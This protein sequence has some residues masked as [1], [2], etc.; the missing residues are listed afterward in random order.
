MGF[1]KCF[2][3]STPSAPA[4]SSPPPAIEPP[5]PAT[6]APAASSGKVVRAPAGQP[7]SA[8]KG[9]VPRT[10]AELHPEYAHSEPYH[11]AAN[12]ASARLVVDSAS[13]AARR[14]GDLRLR[15]ADVPQ[16]KKVVIR[17]PSYSTRVAPAAQARKVVAATSPRSTPKSPRSGTKSSRKSGVDTHR[18]SSVDSGRKS[19][20]D[21]PRKSM[22]KLVVESPAT[23]K[24]DDGTIQ[25]EN[26]LAAANPP[27]SPPPAGSSR[28]LSRFMKGG[29]SPRGK[30][31]RGKSP[32]GRS[33]APSPLRKKLSDA[34][35]PANSPAVNAAIAHTRSSQGQAQRTLSFDDG[36]GVEAA[37]RP[38]S[39][40]DGFDQA[41]AAQKR[42]EEERV[43][44]DQA[45]Y[46]D[47]E[48][49]EEPEQEYAY[50]DEHEQ[51][52]EADEEESA[53]GQYDEE[54]ASSYRSARDDEEQSEEEEEEEEEESASD[55]EA[56]S[57]PSEGQYYQQYPD[58]DRQE[59]S[60][61]ESEESSA[62]DRAVSANG[63]LTEDHAA[64][65][66]SATASVRSSIRSSVRS[67]TR[68]AAMDNYSIDSDYVHSTDGD[69][70]RATFGFMRDS[71]KTDTTVDTTT[72]DA[73]SDQGPPSARYGDRDDQDASF[74]SASSGQVS[75]VREGSFLSEVPSARGGHDQFSDANDSFTRALAS[76]S[77]RT[78]RR[79]ST[80]AGR[81]VEAYA[82]AVAASSPRARKPARAPASPH[83]GQPRRSPARISPGP[84]ENRYADYSDSEGGSMPSASLVPIGR[85]GS[86]KTT[87][88]PPR[89]T[90]SFRVDKEVVI[91]PNLRERR[92]QP[93]SSLP[94]GI[95]SGR[96][97]VS[98]LK[99]QS[100]LPREASRPSLASGKPLV[101]ALRKTQAIASPIES[102]R[103]SPLPG[104]R[105]SFTDLNPNS[106]F[107]SASSSFDSLPVRRG[108]ARLDP[109]QSRRRSKAVAEAMIE[110]IKGV[111]K[112][113]MLAYAEHEPE[114]D[115]S[116]ELPTVQLRG[117]LRP[118][119]RSGRSMR[120]PPVFTP[121]VVPPP[122]PPPPF[123]PEPT[124]VRSVRMPP[125][126]PK[127]KKNRMYC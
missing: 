45:G 97:L 77:R 21:G 111:P 83:P 81:K 61:S 65:N 116:G 67:S 104:P 92:H 86:K 82:A 69:R 66:A 22:V 101:S 10:V 96:M 40:V 11:F 75:T 20:V 68:S 6:S 124:R 95:G 112:S 59:E 70:V 78:L 122:P 42:A 8:S 16:P 98:A 62:S 58:A 119:A 105:V 123:A 3:R 110:Q 74:A 31:P 93:S 15:A 27:A 51:E 50:E 127:A 29:F 108:S 52:E 57:A 33:P 13:R 48:E 37:P 73:M 39:Y 35:P 4:L 91:E 88:A 30:S 115:M 7:T 113:A 2:N 71:A 46:G 106:S 41:A 56:S 43:W 89:K 12:T 53:D 117:S 90:V 126:P 76:G 114:D 79:D 103:A 121:G 102:P 55:G 107:L 84:E 118:R 109:E 14:T 32:R 64:S 120:L 94:R 5:P 23:Y 72:T 28:G 36:D 63:F 47:A 125:P 44:E 100:S 87:R 49:E 34:K 19:S 99:K 54:E 17:G 85:S 80:I 38:P 1:L 26:D 60:A 24:R 9:F 18:K 25:D